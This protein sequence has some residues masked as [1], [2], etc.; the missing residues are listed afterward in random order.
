MVCL[1]DHLPVGREVGMTSS[2]ILFYFWGCLPGQSYSNNTKDWALVHER[3]LLV[4]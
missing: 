1:N 3:K 2:G 4:F